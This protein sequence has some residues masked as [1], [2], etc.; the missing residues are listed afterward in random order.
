MSEEPYDYEKRHED[1]IYECDCGETIKGFRQF[2]EHI[3]EHY[4]KM[5]NE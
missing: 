3:R 4:E 5:V 1:T 2:K